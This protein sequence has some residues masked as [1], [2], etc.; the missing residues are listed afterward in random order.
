MNQFNRNN[1]GPDGDMLAMWCREEEVMVMQLPEEL[2]TSS[3][4]SASSHSNPAE[5]PSSA[6]TAMTSYR[7]LTPVIAAVDDDEDDLDDEDL[8][9]DELDMDDDLEET[10]D[11]DADVDDDDLDDDLDLDDDEDDEDEDI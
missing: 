8:D 9:D 2:V 4:T 10:D 3:L 11:L 5:D 7:R 1:K 6:L